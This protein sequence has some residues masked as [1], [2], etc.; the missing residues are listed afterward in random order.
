MKMKAGHVPRTQLPGPLFQLSVPLPGNA[1]E[2]LFY[3]DQP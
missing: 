3:S 2:L 1:V